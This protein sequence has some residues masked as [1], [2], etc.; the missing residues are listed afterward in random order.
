MN[1]AEL[2]QHLGGP[3]KVAEILNLKQPG[4]RFRV[5]NWKTRGIPSK[6]KVDHPDIFL[7]GQP[8]LPRIRASADLSHLAPQKAA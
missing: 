1:D 2:I 7:R 5:Q 6:I 3:A 4:G 8:E